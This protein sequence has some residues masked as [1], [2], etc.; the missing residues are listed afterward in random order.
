MLDTMLAAQ[1]GETPVD[2][3]GKVQQN[4]TERRRFA[5]SRM[6][7]SRGVLGDVGP[8]WASAC[9]GS[10]RLL[11]QKRRDIGCKKSKQH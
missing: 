4:G 1:L 6:S 5:S 9:T 11:K 7:S 10:T 2:T 3:Q 8:S